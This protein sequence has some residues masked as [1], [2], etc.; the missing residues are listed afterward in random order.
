V[1]GILVEALPH[2][3]YMK[4][5]D[6]ST[7]PSI[8]EPVCSNYEGN[9]QVNEANAPQLVHQY[10]L[11]KM[12][13]DEDIETMYSR[14][15]TLVSG[16]EFLKKSYA[17]P[18]HVKKIMSS[19]PARFRSKVTA[20]QEAKDLDMLILENLIS[21][22]KSHEIELEG[23]EP[24]NL[25]KSVALTSKEKTSKS[26]QTAKSE[27]KGSYDESNDKANFKEMD[28]LTKRFQFLTKKRIFPSKSS[29]LKTSSFKDKRDNRKV[30]FNYGKIGHFIVDCPEAYN[31]KSGNGS[32]KRDTYMRKLKQSF[33]TTWEMLDEDADSDDNK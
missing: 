20:I 30:C 28:Y 29:D 2:A 22:L 25:S 15:Q 32:S 24:N 21:Y 9:Q 13:E 4:I 23:E 16:L 1:R 17:T 31:G 14:F 5:G 3:E 27:E 19:L 10:E 8:F 11:F 12:K 33:M 26:I 7:K 6:R 18:N